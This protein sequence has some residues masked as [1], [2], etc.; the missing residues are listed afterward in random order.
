MYKK[1]IVLVF[2]A[3]L[4]T[5]RGDVS[6]RVA[7][8][9]TLLPLPNYEIVVGSPVTLIIHSDANEPWRG[10]LFIRDLDRNLGELTGRG[11]P[12]GR[13]H[14]G[15]CLPEAGDFRRVWH[16]EDS[17]I[18]GFDLY[19]DD[20]LAAPGDWFVVDYQPIEPGLCTIEF[21]DYTQPDPNCWIQP[22][23]TI[24]LENTPSRDF[25]GNGLVNLED[26]AHLA[27]YWLDEDCAD[28]DWCAQTDLDRD[29]L[30][31]LTDLLMFSEYW[32]WGAAGW[33]PA[34]PPTDP[35]V[36]YA[37]TDA[38]GLQEIDLA[39]GESV[40]LYM[41]K[42]TFEKD[43]FFFHLEAV[44]SDTSLGWIDNTVYDANDPPGPGTARILTSPRL[45]NFDYWGPG[46]YQPEGIQF[47]ALNFMAPMQDGQLTSFVY[48]ATA[49]GQVTLSLKDYGQIHC[50]RQTMLIHQVAPMQSMS[51]DTGFRMMSMSSA[52]ESESMETD[53]GLT[54]EDTVEFLET[55]WEQE[56][57]LRESISRE[58][59]DAFLKSFEESEQ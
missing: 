19:T 7:D 24:Q 32:L 23:S 35:N 46:I 58:D 52:L 15:N 6:L 28:P 43:V 56:P 3:L 37:I 27:R 39:V 20:L 51:M 11:D 44:I 8:P 25:T 34:P 41:Q 10:G 48:T 16:W 22:F 57:E 1:P 13:H 18:E 30:V 53:S 31:A 47:S 59:W 9:N 2:L 45:T 5:G 49:P 14:S 38:Q 12:N 4:Q 50:L 40:T 26:Y 54:P 17:R 36:I 21:Y 55:L 33:K 29:G 42:T